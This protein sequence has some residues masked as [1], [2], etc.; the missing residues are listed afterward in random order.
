MRSQQQDLHFPARLL[1]AEQPA[2]PDARVVDYQEIPR[3]KVRR[4]VRKGP[5]LERSA[6]RDDQEAG[7][8]PMGRRLLGDPLGRQSVIEVPER[9]RP[10][11]TA[12]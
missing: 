9:Q 1:A 4:Q 8:L 12:R 2:L 10:G 7:V 5:V 11:V 3:A 6:P